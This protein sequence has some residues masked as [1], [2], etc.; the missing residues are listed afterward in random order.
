[1]RWQA[2]GRYVKSPGASALSSLSLSLSPFTA[3]YSWST[4][5]KFSRKLHILSG[6]WRGETRAEWP[7]TQGAVFR[8]SVDSVPR[9]PRD[10]R[11]FTISASLVVVVDRGSVQ[12]IY[13]PVMH[14]YAI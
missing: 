10:S 1:M 11:A 14:N 4:V 7:V 8:L 3:D 12:R 6:S 5:I 9:E 2:Q 13:A